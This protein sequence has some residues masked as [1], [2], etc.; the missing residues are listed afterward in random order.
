MKVK[1]RFLVCSMLALL[2]GNATYAGDPVIQ[3]DAKALE[4]L[5]SMSAYTASLDQVKI[6]AVSLDDARLPDGLMVTNTSEINISIDRP[7][8][9]H[10]NRFDGV[11]NKGLF[12]HNGELTV[13]DSAENFYAQAEVPEDIEAAMEFALEELDVE[14]PLMDMIYRDASTHLI[15][16]ENVI[17]YLTD[18]ARLA[19][20]DCHHIAIR[21]SEIDV[22]L[23]VE[24]GDKPLP[25]KI[26]ITSKWEGGS[27]RFTANMWWNSEPDISA[28]IF[29]FRAPD[30][31]VKISFAHAARSEGD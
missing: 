23:W 21:G 19:G 8:S 6:K 4:V 26:M 2:A 7:A 20:I 1:I 17:L 30:G 25:R 18:K 29:E 13:F 10:I 12:F 24:E 9:L 27:P 5:K 11:A 22:Q 28:D 15:G 16:S 31:A 14:A 3:Q